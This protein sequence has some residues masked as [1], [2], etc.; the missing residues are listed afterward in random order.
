MAALR[1]KVV[2]ARSAVPVVEKEDTDATV[3]CPGTPAAVTS[4]PTA[5]F[6]KLD[7][8]SLGELNVTAVVDRVA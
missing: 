6:A 1:V 3:V 7:S 4:W 5:T 8:V 2:L